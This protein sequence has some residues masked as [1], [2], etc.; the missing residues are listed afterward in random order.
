MCQCGERDKSVYTCS[1]YPTMVGWGDF[2]TFNRCKTPSSDMSCHFKIEM[3][4]FGF[5]SL[6]DS[7]PLSVPPQ[8]SA[9]SPSV[10]L[11]SFCL[12]FA[13]FC[14]PESP[15]Y[16]HRVRFTLHLCIIVS[17]LTLL[18]LFHFRGGGQLP[19]HFSTYFESFGAYPAAYMLTF[20]ISD[21]FINE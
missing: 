2:I 5:Y 14:P 11:R 9:A 20:S 1:L 13:I 4:C 3:K 16:L 8:L 17:K 7:I 21:E 6:P 12:S 10:A 19:V 18:D 15:V